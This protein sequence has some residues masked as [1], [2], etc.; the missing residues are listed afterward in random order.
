[1]F[2]ALLPHVDA[3]RDGFIE[4]PR[5]F[6]PQSLSERAFSELLFCKKMTV[7]SGVIGQLGQ[8]FISLPAIRECTWLRLYTPRTPVPLAVGEILEWLKA[9]ARSNEPKVLEMGHQTLNDSIDD[10]V[11]QLQTVGVPGSDD[12]C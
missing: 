12:I 7:V 10:F 4:T 1:M 11:Q 6:N 8:P 9:D 2:E 5:Y 3:W